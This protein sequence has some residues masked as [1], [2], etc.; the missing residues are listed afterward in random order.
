[1]LDNF[2]RGIQVLRGV[3]RWQF[4]PESFISILQNLRKMRFI[5]F[6]VE[7]IHS[8]EK[9]CQEFF[10]KLSLDSSNLQ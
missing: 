3:H 6:N 1:M 10:V 8:T 7:L 4:T 5:S 2:E 9:G